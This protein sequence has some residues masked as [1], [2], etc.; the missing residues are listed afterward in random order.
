MA[1][2]REIARKAGVSTCT[3]SR[4]LNN[5][6]AVRQETRDMVQAVANGMGYRGGGARRVHTAVGLA[7]TADRT[8]SSVYDAHLVEG[9]VR[10]L[11]ECRF[12]LSIIN[13]MRDKSRDE[14][15]N[16]FFTRRGVSGVILRTTAETRHV[17]E[18]IAD[19]NFPM[20]VVGE[21]FDA[22][23][24][25]YIDCDT[26]A[27]SA[28]AV[29]Y[30]VDLGHRR[31]A[32]AMHVVPDRDHIDRFDA[33]RRVLAENG[34]AFDERLVFRI[35]SDLAGGATVTNMLATMED[36]PTAVYAADPLLAVGV[37]KRAY[38]LGI[39]I[40]R[41]LSVI[42]ID[43]AQVRYSVPPT[44]TAVCQDAATLGAEAA[45][46][47]ARTITGRVVG[48]LRK[49]VPSFFEVHNSTA[50]PREGGRLTLAEGGANGGDV[51]PRDDQ[52]EDPSGQV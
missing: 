37:A 52:S 44:L 41:D 36:P 39:H 11:E 35:R 29:Q 24:V 51:R 12:D 34:L 20:I 49:S 8:L 17:C 21:R 6:P 33:Y 5:H 43:D 9:I 13:I 27:D 28:R 10:G 31:I 45:S 25:S 38:Q 26:S 50:S 3:V 4:A 30:L 14:S 19:E 1:S 48:P 23:N 47:L 18:E 15:Y 22:P 32:F 16:Q 46:Y 40:P 7:H 42:G 2:V